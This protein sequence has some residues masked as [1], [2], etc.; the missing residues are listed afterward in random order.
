MLTAVDI[1]NIPYGMYKKFEEILYRLRECQEV[2]EVDEEHYE[3]NIRPGVQR[4]QRE[5]E[6]REQESL[7]E[8]QRQRRDQILRVMESS[9]QNTEYRESDE[10]DYS[11]NYSEDHSVYDDYDE[12]YQNFR[13][14]YA[15]V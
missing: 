11:D 1:S 7:S 10:D 12:D 3:T 9:R 6:Q 15:D 2:T 4:R 8:A 5:R 13:G 14:N